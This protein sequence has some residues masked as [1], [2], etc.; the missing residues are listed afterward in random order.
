ML[1]IGL[2]LASAAM[3]GLS[4]FIG[5]VV[6]RR[7][8]A[9]AVGIV[10]QIA[11]FVIIGTATLLLV[12]EPEPQ[13]LL[14]GALAGIGT[15]SGTAFLYR[16]LA[17][18][19]MG[20]VA[21]LSAVGAALLPVAVGVLTGDR[22]P[23]LT[24]IGIGC[25]VPAIWLVSSAAEPPESSGAGRLGEGVIDGTLAG[26]G[27][28]LMFAALAQVPD[29]AGLAPLA[30][31]EVI[32]IGTIIVLAT[33][34]RQPW[35]PRERHAWW[36]VVVGALAAIAAV[37]FLFASQTGMLAVAAVLTSLYPVF[38]VLLAATVLRERIQGPQAV[39]LGLAA[40]AVAL[41]AVG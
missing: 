39:G 18:G 14:W 35:V 8:S 22:P 11:A 21:P 31:A 27:F 24:W 17:N 38:T 6:S 19:R 1:T 4:D 12:A 32:A 9:W 2:A 30:V 5:G 15:G 13:D 33:V 20:V 16:G 29:A 23:M 26:L 34:M 28:G 36:G 25:A 7:A 40:V 41:V 10:T 3:Y 37:C